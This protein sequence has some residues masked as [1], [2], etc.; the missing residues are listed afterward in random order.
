MD[1]HLTKSP[2]SALSGAEFKLGSVFIEIEKSS[3]IFREIQT[4]LFGLFLNSHTESKAV[5]GRNCC[6]NWL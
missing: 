4:G 6:D 5:R 2:Y 3:K 1:V